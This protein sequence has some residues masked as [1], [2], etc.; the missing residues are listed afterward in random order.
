MKRI[1]FVL[2][3]FIWGAPAYSTVI[4]D[5]VTG[6]DMAG[7]EV[8]A[9]FTG[10]G[11][12]TL[13][14]MTTR[15]DGS[16]ANQEGFSGGAFGTGWSLMQQGNTFGDITPSGDLLGVW[17][18]VSSST[19]LAMIEIN[20]LAGGFVFD[21]LFGSEGTPGS[22]V[23]RDFTTA[24][25]GFT[26]TYGDLYSAPDLYGS[27][28]LDWGAAGFGSGSTLLFMADTDQAAVPEPAS[29]LLLATGLFGMAGIRARAKR[30]QEKKEV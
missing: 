25:T 7:I 17:T 2:S 13:T 9:Y 10:G 14:W 28:T 3:L 19:T 8:T 23:G 27:L 5:N 26:A 21:N 20:T 11:S 12:E 4:T 24:G 18:L 16:I 1:A 22:G 30:K 15:T 6:A 29:A